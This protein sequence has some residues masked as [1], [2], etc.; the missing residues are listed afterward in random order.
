MTSGQKRKIFR[1]RGEAAFGLVFWRPIER[2][3][4]YT[5]GKDVYKNEAS[6]GFDNVSELLMSEP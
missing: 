5:T 2:S 3:F 4:S 1:S 6:F